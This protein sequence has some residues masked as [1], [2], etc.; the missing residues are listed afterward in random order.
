M[1][2]P[3]LVL[4]QSAPRL[5][6]TI[7]RLQ[8]KAGGDLN[9]TL[10]VTLN[11]DTLRQPGELPVSWN[12]VK[13]VLHPN[14]DWIADGLTLPRTIIGWSA[15]QMQGSA[16]AV[17]PQPQA[18]NAACGMLGG[19]DW[20]GI[21]LPSLT[22]YPYTMNLVSG[23]SFQTTVQ[24]WGVNDQG[25]CGSLNTGPFTAPL[26][27]GSIS[28]SSVTATVQYSSL[29]ATYNGLDVYVPSA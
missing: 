28:F 6:G 26:L 20:V 2:R 10:S 17:G 18:G 16:C 29:T 23:S 1:S 19:A 4:T 5:K 11:D 3:A 12:G 8:G 15:F 21:N 9:A 24:G 25:L 14:G 22:V 13:S 7:D 27:A